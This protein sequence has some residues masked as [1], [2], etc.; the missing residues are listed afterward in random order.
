ML[1]PSGWKGTLA[2][3]RDGAMSETH[4]MSEHMV[5]EQTDILEHV[6]LAYST[7]SSLEQPMKYL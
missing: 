3:G 7:V 1:R 6:L 5:C 4:T 2:G